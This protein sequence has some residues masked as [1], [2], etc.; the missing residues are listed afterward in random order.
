[1]KTK[2]LLAILLVIAMA[3]IFCVSAFAEPNATGTE[4]NQAAAAITKEL[5]MPD[6]RHHYSVR[7]GTEV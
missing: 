4:A 6:P 3:T 2:N 7:E 1:M 5:K